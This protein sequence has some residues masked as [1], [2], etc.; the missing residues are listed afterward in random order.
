MSFTKNTLDKKAHLLIKPNIDSIDYDCKNCNGSCCKRVDKKT[1]KIY[2]CQYLDE[3]NLC[4]IYEY[5]PF[6]CRLDNRF[7]SKASLEMHCK[8]CQLSISESIT[9]EK[10]T[11]KILSDLIGKNNENQ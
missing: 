9:G 7:H 8:T 11:M 6:A 3:N 2:S 1:R 10:A 4:L 5:R